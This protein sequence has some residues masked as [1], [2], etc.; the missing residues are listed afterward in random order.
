LYVSPSTRKALEALATLLLDYHYSAHAIGRITAYAA[1]NG[2]PSG[3]IYLDREDEEDACMVFEQEQEPV[4]YDHESWGREDVFLD[5][6]LLA[7]GVHPWPI[8]A[9][10]DDDRDGSF[11]PAPADW[12]AIRREGDGE[13]MFG[14]E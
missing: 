1:A 3:S 9:F 12:A 11:E 5:V 6:E 2:T 8:P 10:G 13:A 4:P 7:Q 14:Y